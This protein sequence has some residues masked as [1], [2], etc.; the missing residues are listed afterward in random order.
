MNI[1]A[2]L[3]GLNNVPQALILLISAGNAVGYN[4][5]QLL[6]HY[7]PGISE[8]RAIALELCGGANEK[9]AVE[10][11]TEGNCIEEFFNNVS[12][13]SEQSIPLIMRAI[14]LAYV[15]YK[16]NNEFE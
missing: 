7:K 16:L 4:K 8:V 10:F 2:G 15:N 6:S 1:L 11:M 5:E 14:N 13:N 12:Y 9:I 3:K